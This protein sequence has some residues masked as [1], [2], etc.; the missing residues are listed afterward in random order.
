MNNKLINLN[1]KTLTSCAKYF[2][3]Q[4]HLISHGLG[5]HLCSYDLSSCDLCSCDDDD[6][7]YSFDDFCSPDD[8][9]D[10]S[11]YNLSQCTLSS[12]H[13][14]ILHSHSVLQ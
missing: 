9:D 14:G 6:D 13:T 12:K 4:E 10:L 1:V 3:I 2:Q 5:T 7:L 8:N 11:S